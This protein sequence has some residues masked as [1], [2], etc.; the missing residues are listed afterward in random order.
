MSLTAIREQI[1]T[2]LSGVSGIGVVHNYQRVTTG[3]WGKFLN[4]FQD[5][6]GRINTWIITRT[7]TPERWL[8]NRKYIRVYEFLIR[9]QYGLEDNEATELRF[10]DL[11]E[12]ACDAFRNKSTLNGACETIAPEFGSLSGLAGLQV[13]LVEDRRFGGVLCHYCELKLGAQVTETRS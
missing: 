8:T 12:H 7:A 10:Q 1:K 2:I 6:D 5:P 9:G 3:D 13:K 4:Q 11:I